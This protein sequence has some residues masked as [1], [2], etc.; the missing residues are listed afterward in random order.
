[1]SSPLA[2]PSSVISS[3]VAVANGI[4][5][6]QY[7][8]CSDF[9]VIQDKRFTQVDREILQI[10]TKAFEQFCE[11]YESFDSDL[12]KILKTRILSPLSGKVTRNSWEQK[13]IQTLITQVDKVVL[14]R[15]L[16]TKLQEALENEWYIS[17][18]DLSVDKK[19]PANYVGSNG[20]DVETNV[21]NLSWKI[22]NSFKE[23]SYAFPSLENQSIVKNVLATL[24]GKCS[25]KPDSNIPIQIDKFSNALSSCHKVLS[26]IDELEHANWIGI[27]NDQLKGFHYRA[28]NS[29]ELVKERQQVLSE[30]ESKHSE[31]EESVEFKLST[32][33]SKLKDY[34]VWTHKIVFKGDRALI[35][36]W[37]EIIKKVAAKATEDEETRLT[38]WV[39]N[40][41]NSMGRLAKRNRS[42]SITNSRSIEFSKSEPPSAVSASVQ[43][44]QEIIFKTAGVP[45]VSK[46]PKRIKISPQEKKRLKKRGSVD[47]DGNS[48]SKPAS[49][50]LLKKD[51]F[52]LGRPLSP[53]KLDFSLAVR[54]SKSAVTKSKS[55]D[56]S[57]V[58]RFQKVI[59]R[60]AVGIQKGDWIR[61]DLEVIKNGSLR[62]LAEYIKAFFLW[63]FGYEPFSEYSYAKI[64]SSIQLFCAKHIE[65]LQFSKNELLKDL[66]ELVIQPIREKTENE[67][68]THPIF[69]IFD[70]IHK[71]L[72]WPDDLDRIE[73]ESIRSSFKKTP[74]QIITLNLKNIKLFQILALLHPDALITHVKFP[75]KKVLHLEIGEKKWT[76]TLPFDV[77]VHEPL[78]GYSGAFPVPE[79]L[80]LV[81]QQNTE[82]EE[83][84]LTGSEISSIMSESSTEGMLTWEALE[85]RWSYRSVLS[86]HEQN[87]L[88][89]L[90]E[91]T[92]YP[93]F[94]HIDPWD[95]SF[96][97]LSV[98]KS[99]LT[100]E[101]KIT[102]ISHLISAISL[103]H[104]TTI[105]VES[106]DNSKVKMPLTYTCV[107]ARHIYLPR[108][109]NGTNS[110]VPRITH[111]AHASSLS[112]MRESAS[113]LPPHLQI[114]TTQSGRFLEAK[115][116]EETRMTLTSRSGE[117]FNR[118]VKDFTDTVE[119]QLSHSLTPEV[120]FENCVIE[121]IRKIIVTDTESVIGNFKK[122]IAE[123]KD[124]EK[125]KLYADLAKTKPKYEIVKSILDEL[126]LPEEQRD[127]SQKTKEAIFVSFKN[128]FA[129]EMGLKESK[130]RTAFKEY[131][132]YKAK[133]RIISDFHKQCSDGKIL[134]E[135]VSRYHTKYGRAD[136]VFLL[137]SL[138]GEVLFSSEETV[139]FHFPIEA[140]LNFYKVPDIMP[141]RKRRE[142]RYTD[143]LKSVTS[144]VIKAMNNEY[145]KLWTI[146]QKGTWRGNFKHQLLKS[147]DAAIK[148]SVGSLYQQI[149]P[150]FSIP[151]I[152][153]SDGTTKKISASIDETI[154]EG[155]RK[156]TEMESSPSYTTSQWSQIASVW[157][158]IIK[159][160]LKSDPEERL[161]IDAIEKRWHEIFPE[162][163]SDS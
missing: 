89:L 19:K 42:L 49:R 97:S 30:H 95:P 59:Q 112:T 38:F 9:T 151:R 26:K 139:S 7:I 131:K 103:M 73:N 87:V 80:F 130:L 86:D 128:T 45:V 161:E 27:E 94:V 60:L 58:D 104:K 141:Y 120:I 11:F 57:D 3:I 34:A 43:E 142:P 147:I 136:D 162:Q 46:R 5:K 52:H 63:L 28:K 160:G 71:P 22:F 72:F 6:N 56:S 144:K 48:Y 92:R 115:T 4:E 79:I 84:S 83:S 64:L 51:L 23:F 69:S 14:T 114:G 96:S 93:Y 81:T 148:T 37:K 18:E 1:M 99:Q 31:E 50:S 70:F 109:R 85:G 55:F 101:E 129:V 76:L 154:E 110:S 88:T 143:H 53:P 77:Y 44:R 132:E 158:Q 107:S 75:N 111:L 74:K 157:E 17:V 2:S 13:K 133:G 163:R 25:F 66:Y 145:D 159:A 140:I 100:F 33:I 124:A 35:A 127:K 121:A 137:V 32:V 152:R 39:N 119:K 108:D 113:H 61:S 10:A 16:F 134:E 21:D 20:Q 149:V 150:N 102:V 29:L 153:Q 105:E 68:G 62:Q 138:I 146:Q 8:R 117:V 98:A 36:K 54:K 106:V 47:A 122:V 91:Q 135:F 155:L 65:L 156:I 82:D 123:Q 125:K 126:K 12:R 118:V 116:N 24:K 40:A 78:P 15:Q 67:N 41:L 90:Q